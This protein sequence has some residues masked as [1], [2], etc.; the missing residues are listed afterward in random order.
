MLE[1]ATEGEVILSVVLKLVMCIGAV[2][3]YDNGAI[4]AEID[5]IGVNN[6]PESEKAFD[7]MKLQTI[8][9][10]MSAGDQEFLTRDS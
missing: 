10:I 7:M 8:F 9:L 2:H 6:S 5:D 3:Y 1:E 4:P